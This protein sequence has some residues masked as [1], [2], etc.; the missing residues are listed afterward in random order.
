MSKKII[1]YEDACAIERVWDDS[2]IKSMPIFKEAS[3]KGNCKIMRDD[4]TSPPSIEILV[5]IPDIGNDACGIF[6]MPH[7]DSTWVYVARDFNGTIRSWVNIGEFPTDD[8]LDTVIGKAINKLNICPVCGKS[9]PFSEQHQY[10]FA[11]RCCK[12]C[13]PAMKEKYEQPG[14]YN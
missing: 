14:W 12:D 10:S 2:D 6:I 13:L 4:N 9:V 8:S 7:K 5:D 3:E 1:S 11:N